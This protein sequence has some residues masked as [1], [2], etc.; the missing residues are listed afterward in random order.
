MQDFLSQSIAGTAHNDFS[1][2]EIICLS[3]R[4]ITA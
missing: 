3:I 4:L 1:P 2:Q